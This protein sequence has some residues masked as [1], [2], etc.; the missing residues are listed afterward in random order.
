MKEIIRYF[1]ERGLKNDVFLG[2]G[3]R[4]VVFIFI[5]LCVVLDFS[6]FR[7]PDAT[8]ED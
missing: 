1:H 4:R 6:V 7:S 2:L 5:G 3:R 8:W